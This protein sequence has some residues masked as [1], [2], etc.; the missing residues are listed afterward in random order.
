[1][2]SYINKSFSRLLLTILNHW[3][4]TPACYYEN[5]FTLKSI[6]ILIADQCYDVPVAPS[7]K[8]E[9]MVSRSKVVQRAV[10]N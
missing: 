4:L 9:R 6:R 3:A 2:K 5:C 7:C 8:M 1:M 10:L